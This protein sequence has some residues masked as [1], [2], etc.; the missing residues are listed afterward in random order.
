M[1][2]NGRHRVSQRNEL[3]ST[4]PL[5]KV[6]SQS[7]YTLVTPDSASIQIWASRLDVDS[8]RREVCGNQPF[9]GDYE[10]F[11]F[12]FFFLSRCPRQLMLGKR[13]RQGVRKPQ[14]RQKME[15]IGLPK[16]RGDLGEWSASVSTERNGDYVCERMGRGSQ[17]PQLYILCTKI[18]DICA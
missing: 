13:Q 14:F 2:S 4:S 11:F 15:D 3:R 1:S 9:T 17:T 16:G 12:F 8:M 6:A 7:V 18:I 5:A 10:S